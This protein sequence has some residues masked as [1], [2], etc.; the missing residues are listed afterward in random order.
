[1]NFWIIFLCL[2]IGAVVGFEFGKYMVSKRVHDTLDNVAKEFQKLSDDLK[3]KK[4]QEEILKQERQKNLTK[5]MTEI[6]P[7]M[8]PEDFRKKM[9][10]DSVEGLPNKQGANEDGQ[11][12]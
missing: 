6:L 8:D 4:E 12:N 11:R 7:K 10:I 2:V 9:G 1:M 3:K 5:L